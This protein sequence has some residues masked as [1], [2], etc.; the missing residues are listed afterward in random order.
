MNKKRFTPEEI[1][2]SM[3]ELESIESDGIFIDINGNVRDTEKEIKQADQEILDGKVNFRMSR[4]E[5]NRCKEIAARKGMKYQA[6][7]RNIVKQA[8]DKDDIAS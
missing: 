4:S 1:E 2:A 5:I 3:E 8:M 6:Y 7:I